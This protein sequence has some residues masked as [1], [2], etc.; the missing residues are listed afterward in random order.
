MFDESKK[1]TIP[2]Y[3]FKILMLGSDSTGKT[4]LSERYIT[5]V[6]EQ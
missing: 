6:Q 1:M 2:D 3:T 4:T 5:G